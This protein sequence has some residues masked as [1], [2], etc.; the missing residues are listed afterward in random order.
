M[1]WQDLDIVFTPFRSLDASKVECFNKNDQANIRAAIENIPGRYN[2][3]NRLSVAGVRHWVYVFM[4]QNLQ[5]IRNVCVQMEER[6]EADNESREQLCIF[7]RVVSKLQR[8]DYERAIL[9]GEECFI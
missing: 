4:E 6:G 9:L 8:G 1:T 3:V 2:G 5:K 7:L